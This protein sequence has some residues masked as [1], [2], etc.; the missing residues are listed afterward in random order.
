MAWARPRCRA[1]RGPCAGAPRPGR[2]LGP[3]PVLRAGVVAVWIVRSAP[4]RTA[5]GVWIAW[6]GHRRHHLRRQPVEEG[7]RPCAV[8]VAARARRSWSGRLGGARR[9]RRRRARAPAGRARRARRGG[10]ARRRRARTGRLPRAAASRAR[11]RVRAAP[12]GLRDRAA[13]GA[14]RRLPARHHRRARTPTRRCR[15]R[16]SSTPAWWATISSAPCAPLWRTPSTT[17]RDARVRRLPRSA[18][19]PST[20]WWRRSYCLACFRS[21]WSSV[22]ER[23]L[24]TSSELSHARRAVATPQRMF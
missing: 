6:S 5:P 21:F 22:H 20:D 24:T 1:A 10:G 23:V 13:R 18:V 9:G 8:G 19:T 3:W 15:S 2:A 14:R 11:V 12:R 4:V 17:T 16:A 7:P